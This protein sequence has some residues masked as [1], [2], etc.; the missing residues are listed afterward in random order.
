VK[1]D[2]VGGSR[3]GSAQ[4]GHG[5]A[6]HIRDPLPQVLS[7]AEAGAP[8]LSAD[9]SRAGSHRRTAA[10]GVAVA[11]RVRRVGDRARP[12]A[13]RG[14]LRLLAAAGVLAAAL[15]L[16]PDALAS[17]GN[18]V[19]QNLG[20]LLR[21]YAGEIYGGITAIVALIFLVNRRYTELGLFLV[22]AVI[23]AWLVFSPDQVASAARAIGQQIFG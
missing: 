23:V 7:S 18:S 16:A 8:V 17:T 2:D 13:R 19:G 11:V 9:G 20:G 1:A 6:A 4:R 15:A 22:A 3:S 10:C 14:W 5:H 21:Q 12:R